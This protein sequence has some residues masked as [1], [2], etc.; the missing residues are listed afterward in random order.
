LPPAAARKGAEH[1]DRA[2]SANSIRVEPSGTMHIELSRR[3]RMTPQVPVPAPEKP[4][5]PFRRLVV[6]VGKP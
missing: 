2:F 5:P 4:R 3:L 6:F 1:V